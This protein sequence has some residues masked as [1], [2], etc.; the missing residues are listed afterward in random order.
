MKKLSKILALMLALTL[1]LSF[2][3]CGGSGKDGGKKNAA[4]TLTV[5]GNIGSAE[6]PTV[7]DE[8]IIEGFKEKTGVTVEIQT[9]S[10]SGY[11]EQLQLM[12]A[13]GEYPD[14]ALFPTTTVQA[15]ID[16]CEAGKVVALDEYLTEEN[17]PNLMAYTYPTAWEGVKP[18][19]DGKIYA[20]PRTSLTRNEGII[21]RADWLKN[22]GLGEY[23]DREFHEVSADEFKELLKRMTED[24]PDNNGKNDTLATSC[25]TDDTTKQF[26]PF[27]FTR[28]F[29]GDYGWYA[30][31]GE[32]YDYMFPQYS[33]KSDIF[34][35]QLAYTQE[36]Q[37]AGYLDK[38]GPTLTKTAVNDNFKQQ[39][40]GLG[41]GFVGDIASHEKSLIEANNNLQSPEGSYV[42]YLFAK[43]DNGIVAGNGYY[44][45]MWGQFCVFTACAEPNNFIQLC[46]YILSDEVW[47]MVANGV[48]GITYEMIG[49]VKTSIQVEPGEQGRGASFP[50]G[51]VR[52][53]GDPE[54]FALRGIDPAKT[55]HMED[56]TL[57]NFHIGQ[58]TQIDSLDNGFVPAIASSTQFITAQD[59]LVQVVTK[60]CAGQME[61]SEYDAALEKWYAQGGKEYVE[62]MNAYITENQASGA[63]PAPEVPLQPSEWTA[64]YDAQKAA[65]EGE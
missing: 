63:A 8:M 20:V 11:L 65:V 46:D 2:V 17:C 50:A 52:K 58:V 35:K 33:Q 64:A 5:F 61:V 12:I 7:I 9:A 28:G 1:V 29:Y 44:K 3:A 16:V 32:D 38:D 59:E 42:E 18:L 34:K 19:D 23:L 14:A 43:D 40:Y 41:I 27:E 51:I 62:Q 24:D 49:G 37:K 48:E 39:R 25:W 15:Y 10:G 60:I 21:V 47:D 45:P 57:N 31:E 26:G 54:F 53:A 4:D 56:I 13:S 6:G 55:A 36:I 30:Y 22:I